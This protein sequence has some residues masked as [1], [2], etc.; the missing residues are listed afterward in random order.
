MNEEEE[1]EIIKELEEME[2]LNLLDLFEIEK[3]K[4]GD[5]AKEGLKQELKHH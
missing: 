3:P 4:Q 2:V 5:L 1:E